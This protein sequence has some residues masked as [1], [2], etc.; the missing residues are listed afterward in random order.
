MPGG[1]VGVRTI[2]PL[3]AAAT[4]TVVA[5]ITA[6]EAGCDDPGHYEVGPAG[7]EL[8]GGCVAPGDLVVPQPAPA[9]PA[10]QVGSPARD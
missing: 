4:L 6:R 8:V 9:K 7:Y 3:L 10:E 2:A 5:V 1:R